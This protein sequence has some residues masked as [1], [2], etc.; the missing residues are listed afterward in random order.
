MVATKD[1]PD[2]LGR[3]LK[4]MSG[5]SALPDQ[6]IIVDASSIPV[7]EIAAEFKPLN[8]KYI[9]HPQ[10]SASK[11]RNVGISAVAPDTDLIGFLDDD[12]EFEPG[13]IEAMLRF[14]YLDIA[15][16]INYR[17]YSNNYKYYW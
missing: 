10:P 9:R 15:S 5:Q 11:Q 3:M 1:R 6:V 14:Q 17:Y 4:S 13:A 8:I 2:D 12:I 16:I 7:Q